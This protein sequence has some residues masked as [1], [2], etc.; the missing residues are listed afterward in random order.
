VRIEPEDVLLATVLARLSEAVPVLCTQGHSQIRQPRVVLQTLP[1][2]EGTRVARIPDRTVPELP[3]AP[4]GRSTE[5]RLHIQ[6]PMGRIQELRG[7]QDHLHHMLVTV[8][9]GAA[10]RLSR[11][12]EYVHD[13]ASVVGGSGWPTARAPRRIILWLGS[14]KIHARIHRAG[15]RRHSF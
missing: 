11:Q 13:G 12:E 3:I 14:F 2:P 7:L 6:D 5:V 9:A 4:P 1:H 10:A 15:G 8:P